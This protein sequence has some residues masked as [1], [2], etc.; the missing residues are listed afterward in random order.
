MA[1][2]R[3]ALLAVALLLA[4]SLSAIHARFLDT[5]TETA[6][7]T[8]AGVSSH[9]ERTAAGDGS[10]DVHEGQFDFDRL[11]QEA[12]TQR[13]VGGYVRPDKQFTNRPVIGYRDAPDHR[14]SQR[15]FGPSSFATSYARWIQAGGARVVPI[16][17]DS[18]KEEL[19]FLLPR[20]T[21]PAPMLFRYT[22]PAL[23]AAQIPAPPVHLGHL[24]YA[25]GVWKGSP[26]NNWTRS[27]RNFCL[28]QI[29]VEL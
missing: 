8:S 7:Q 10:P 23:D 4:A 1:R 3:A 25:A 14:P 18:T 11:V 24:R 28:N 12:Q 2:A 9:A 13:R 22:A 17:Y 20:Y 27:F 19:D 29:A 15:K 26:L 6:T 16:F 5:A 21:A